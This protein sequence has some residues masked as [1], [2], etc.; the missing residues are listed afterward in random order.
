MTNDGIKSQ[1]FSEVLNMNFN[2]KFCIPVHE[3]QELDNYVTCSIAVN[4]GNMKI[5]GTLNKVSTW[6]K[7]EKGEI[8]GI[9]RQIDM[10]VQSI[11]PNDATQVLQFPDKKYQI[12]EDFEIVIGEI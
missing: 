6:K 5:S 10:V 11:T 2:W 7:K 9:Y 3:M 1:K 4:V 8:V 12:L